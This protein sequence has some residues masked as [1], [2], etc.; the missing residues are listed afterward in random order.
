MITYILVNALQITIKYSNTLN[1]SHMFC[2]K[3]VY[4]KVPWISYEKSYIHVCK[5]YCALFYVYVLFYIS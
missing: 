2:I 3:Q 4:N 5:I 1:Q